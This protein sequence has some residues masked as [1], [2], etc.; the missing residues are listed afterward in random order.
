ME[1]KML[2]TTWKQRLFIAIIA[3]IML[4]STIAVYMM[5]VL[6]G[7]K[8]ATDRAKSS[9]EIAS[10]EEALK[11]K[12]D[13]VASF[14]KQLSTKYF[15]TLKQHKK[16]VKSYNAT[17]ANSAGLKTVDLKAGSG[18]II[19]EKTNY[20][21]YYIGWCADESV[22]DS[23]FDDFKK[24]ATL[25]SPISGQLGL[26]AGWVEGV[27]GMKVGGI[28]ELSIP[29]ELAY[30]DSRDD[31]CGMKSAPLKFIVLTFAP[32]K[33]YEGLIKERSI[34]AAQLQALSAKSSGG[35]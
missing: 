16:R 26:I 2:Q 9:S 30:G 11:K 18:E 8:Q 17:A 5:I 14:E 28:R 10:L 32:D 7:N 23:S 27:K 24:P 21:A 25:K 1:E 4:G 35:F 19:K 34:I 29:G 15:E 12:Q 20:Y 6:N 31:I 3:V 22:F 33:D 13:E